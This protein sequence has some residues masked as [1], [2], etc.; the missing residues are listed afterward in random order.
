MNNP[1]SE[2]LSEQS[3]SQ[4]AENLL[5]CDEETDVVPKVS[6]PESEVEAIPPNIC[7]QLPLVGSPKPRH[8][9]SLVPSVSDP[10]NETTSK[11]VT[12]PLSK[13]ISICD[14]ENSKVLDGLG[15]EAILPNTNSQL[16]IVKSPKLKR[17]FSLIP[18][19]NDPENEIP[20]IRIQ[21][22]SPLTKN[23]SKS[24]KKNNLVSDLSIQEPEN[25][26]IQPNTNLRSP[27]IQSPKPRRSFSLIPTINDPENE[28]T[29]IQATSPLSRKL[30]KCD[31]ENSIVPEVSILEPE[32]EE[33]VASNNYLQ[34][35]LVIP[36]K[37]RRRHS[38][39]SGFD[40]DNGGGP[41][42][43]PDLDGASPGLVLQHL[44]QR[45]ESFLYKSDSDFEISPKSMSRNSSIA[46]EAG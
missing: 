28:K 13:K 14:F 20:S 41:G 23:L 29:S 37:P 25:E 32:A 45:R 15:A 4:L 39:F 31:L 2:S 46:S 3:T 44:P 26:T 12:S 40:V 42:N 38:W 9:F 5:N 30:L 1:E 16:P 43:R 21:A 33:S 34:L 27:L 8:S 36:P 7:L 24:E 18:T 11:Q 19:I 35:P 22:T 10:E 17:S 6:I